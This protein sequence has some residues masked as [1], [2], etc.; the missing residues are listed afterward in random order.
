MKFL[1]F[2]I[3][4]NKSLSACPLGK[5]NSGFVASLLGIN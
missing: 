4:D 1:T 5:L 3:G 2:L